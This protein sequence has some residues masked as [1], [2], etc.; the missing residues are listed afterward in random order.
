MARHMESVAGHGA[1]SVIVT[2]QGVVEAHG[3]RRREW[4]R[5]VAVTA[6]CQGV[7]EPRRICHR[8]WSRVVV[9][10]TACQ[11]VQACRPKFGRSLILRRSSDGNHLSRRL[12]QGLSAIEI[13]KESTLDG[14]STI[15]LGW[16]SDTDRLW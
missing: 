6:A 7:M 8:E 13:R 10:T 16:E 9:I 5:I 14:S 15:G 1:V 2:H 4:S 3:I 11:G 12:S